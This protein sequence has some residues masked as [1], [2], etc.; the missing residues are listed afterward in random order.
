[1]TTSQQV[2]AVKEKGRTQ[3]KR[4]APK[5]SYLHGQNITANIDINTKSVRGLSRHV[6]PRATNNASILQ[7][8]EVN[9]FQPKGCFTAATGWYSGVTPQS[10]QGSSRR[11]CD[12]RLRPGRSGLSACLHK[13]KMGSSLFGPAVDTEGGRELACTDGDRA[14][15]HWMVLHV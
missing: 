7:F 5:K 8:S 6:T 11:I 4:T 15:L 13:E 12:V 14:R 1:M 9:P 10:V 3:A 2:V